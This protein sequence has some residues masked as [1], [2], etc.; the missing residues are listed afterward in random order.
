LDDHF[1]RSRRGESRKCLQTA[2][3]SRTAVNQTIHPLCSGTMHLERLIMV[4]KP[5][6]GKGQAAP[7]P[8][9]S[10]HKVDRTAELARD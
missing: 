2:A 3:R 9:P 4:A 7:N 6:G 10:G 5:V 1:M 8:L